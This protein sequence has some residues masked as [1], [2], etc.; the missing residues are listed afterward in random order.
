MRELP[1]EGNTEEMTSDQTRGSSVALVVGALGVVFGDIG[2]SPLYAMRTILGEGGPLS[3]EVVYGLTSTVIW[4]LVL[5]VTVLYVGLLLRT[6]NEGEGGL[7][8]LVALLRRSSGARAATLTTVLGMVGAAMFLG[9]CVITPAISVLSAAEG[10]E[11]A[12]PS[13][14]SWVLPV[15]LVL[16]AGVFVLQRIGSGVIGRFYGPV[17]VV[18]FVVL[19]VGG[20]ASLARDPGALQALSPLCAFRYFL[21]EPLTAFLALGAVILAV[22]GA[23]ALY[24]D[25]GHF[26][27]A[28]IT[29]AWLFVV[30]PALVLAYL[31]EAAEVVSDPAAA[32]NPFY[33]G[34]PSWATFPVLVLATMATVIASEAVIAGAFTVLHQAGGLGLFPSLRTQ[35][36]STR[37]AGQIYVPA[38]NW[39]LAAGVLVVVLLFRDSAGLSAA[40]GVA[41]SATILV[42]VTL[43]LL[44][45]RDGG[46]RSVPRTLIAVACLLVVLAFFVASLPKI[47]SGGWAPV[48]IGLALLV[49]MSTWWS[50]QRRLHEARQSVEASPDEMLEEIET[51]AGDRISGSAV[52]L[53]EDSHVAPLALRTVVESGYRLAEH[54]VLLSWHVEDTPAA[55][56][57]RSAVDVETYGGRYEGIISVDV[58]LG[59]RERLDVTHVLQEACEADPD[60]LSG[61]DPEE[62]RYFLSEPIPRLD[63]DNGM[64]L[65]RQRLFLLVVRLSTDRIEQL[66]LPRERTV[67]IGREFDL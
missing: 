9:D 2:T 41:V 21:D 26:G 40:Y 58:T 29:R 3:T 57:N 30:F 38:A 50:G 13:L 20:A 61:V 22:T 33:A 49:V 14:S 55:P 54:V 8:A 32:A 64:A 23:E 65:W 51:G 12:S 15:A 19:A 39:A 7:L 11:V 44:L 4:A 46:H 62:A 6:D 24:A 27:R 59:Y 47:L 67:T 37:Q 10:L 31:G 45:Q 28:A 43:Y 66:D 5:V 35:H 52:F 48:S 42:T 16:L 53:T 36:T 56:A 63:R 1:V 60:G 17:M 18:W 34:V 25:L